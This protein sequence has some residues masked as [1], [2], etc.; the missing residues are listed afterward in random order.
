MLLSM[1]K[2]PYSVSIVLDREFGARISEL[3]ESGPVWVVDSPINRDSAQKLWAEFPSRNHLDGASI[4]KAALDASP[5][6]TLFNNMETINLHHGVYS[7]NPAYTAVNVIGCNLTSEIQEFLAAF[8]FNS[9]KR[10]NHGF[11]A[12]RSLPPPLSE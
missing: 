6:Q 3:L 12:T 4:F 11:Q 8:G 2:V 7:A 5:A 10:T 1:S 9:F